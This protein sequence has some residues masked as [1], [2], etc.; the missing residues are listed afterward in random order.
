M[1]A[2]PALP[3]DVEA[4]WRPLSV[5]EMA[6]VAVLLEDAWLILKA[7]ISGAEARLDAATLSPQL[8]VAV[9][10]AMVLRVMRNPDGLRQESIDDYSWTRDNAVSSGLL[11]LSDDELAMLEPAG[12]VSGAFTITP[13]GGTYVAAG[14]SLASLDPS[15]W[16]W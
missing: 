14:Y 8:V 7:R 15:W 16:G 6:V 13:S 9:E 4:R 5:A 1:A 2:N 10:A 11:Y 12:A 3:A